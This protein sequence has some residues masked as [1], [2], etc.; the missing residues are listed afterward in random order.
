[1]I[2]PTDVL[3]NDTDLARRVLAVARS[4][5]PCISSLPDGEERTTAI[6]L[7][8]GIAVEAKARGSRLVANQRIGPAA[9]EYTKASSW[10]SDDDRAAL[11]ALCTPSSEDASRAPAGHFPQGGL[12][13]S[14][15][16]DSER[17]N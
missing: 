11:R 2:E 1:M 10:F 17:Y 6:A 16:P 8:K 14:L 7:L 5:A 4:I 15:W 3:P 13:A 12:I 9:V